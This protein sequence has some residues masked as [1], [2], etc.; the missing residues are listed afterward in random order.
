MYRGGKD[1]EEEEGEGVETGR[2]E[3]RNKRGKF[4]VIREG[5]YGS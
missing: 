4:G 1:R 5:D 3:G 2:E